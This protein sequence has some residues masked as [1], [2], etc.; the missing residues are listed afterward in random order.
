MTVTDILNMTPCWMV[1]YTE[2]HAV[3]ILT[4]VAEKYSC[5]C[6]IKYVESMFQNVANILPNNTASYINNIVKRHFSRYIML[7]NWERHI[8]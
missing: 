1:V 6:Y 3:P 4:I 8:S 7:T 2:E 5:S